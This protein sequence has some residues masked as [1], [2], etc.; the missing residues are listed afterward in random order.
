M[1]TLTL[2]HERALTLLFAELETYA[3]QQSAVFPDS[4]GSL[5]ERTN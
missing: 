4:S 2:P 5:E 1:A 3:A